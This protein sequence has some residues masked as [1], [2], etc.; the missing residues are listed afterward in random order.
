MT[1]ISKRSAFATTLLLAAAL[2]YGALIL[3]TP[4]RTDGEA[5][6]DYTLTVYQIWGSQEKSV[7]K[8][9]KGLAPVLKALAKKSKKHKSFRLAA[10]PL[11]KAVK[12]GGKELATDLP[13][14]YSAAWRIEKRAVK[15]GKKKVGI[16]QALTNPKKKKAVAFFP[17]CPVI[18]EI[19][20]IRNKSDEFILYVDF[21]KGKPKKVK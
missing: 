5:G 11:V 9:T 13:S 17:K 14:G 20:R 7:A 2:F 18:Q 21:K 19:P 16:R 3:A 12:L 1:S 4:V 8:P 6:E 10:K 15:R